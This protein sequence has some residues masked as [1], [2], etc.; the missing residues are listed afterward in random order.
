[1]FYKNKRKRIC[2][3]INSI[4][5]GGAER[6]IVNL[7]KEFVEHGYDVFLITSFRG[8]WE[9]NLSNSVHRLSL[10]GE[11]L[12]QGKIRRNLSR[13]I[14][15][16]IILKK[17]MPD[18]FISFMAEPSVRSIIASTKLPIKTLI[19]VR[20]DPYREYP[21]KIG[22]LLR[23]YIIPK[24]DGCIF[25]TDDAMQ[26]F[27]KEFREKSIVIPNAVK[28][29][30]YKVKRNPVSR[31][32][33]MCGRLEEQKNYPIVI[34]AIKKVSEYYPDIRLYIYGDGSL[35]D[36]L[37]EIIYSYGLIDNIFLMG[38]SDDIPSVLSKASIYVLSSD[39]EGM[40]NALMEALAASVPSISTDCPCGGPKYLIESMK[41]GILVSVR[42]SKKLSEAILY[43][44]DNPEEAEEM[45][46]KA[47]EKAEKYRE[48]KI[49]KKW[50]EY[51]RNI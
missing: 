12:E 31:T 39:Y 25:Q 11:E 7:S 38:Q 6:V 9:Y 33:V 16:R 32:I 14:K 35:R 49:F 4:R 45:G 10:E 18:Y 43:M 47:K 41:D 30:F 51:L 36:K 27:P 21:G 20:N 44:L 26:A 34:E 29:E 42:N 50:E 1:M 40:P 24:A 37:K 15:L 13:I 19:S 22:E 48:D 28:S 23:K 17:V 5:G 3:Y 46:L 8:E 2:F